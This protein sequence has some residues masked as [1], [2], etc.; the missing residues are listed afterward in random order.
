QARTAPHP[1]WARWRPARAVHGH[2]ERDPRPTGLAAALSGTQ[3]PG[4]MRQG[5]PG[6]LH[7][8][9]PG[10]DQRHAQGPKALAISAHLKKT[11]AP[12]SWLWRAARRRITCQTWAC[13]PP[14]NPSSVHLQRPIPRQAVDRPRN[15]SRDSPMTFAKRCLFA[16]F[17]L[18]L[19]LA[20]AA[21][22]Q[23]LEIDIIGGNASA[24]P[25]AVVPMPYQGAG[26]AP[27]TDVSAVVQI[28]RASCRE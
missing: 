23:G 12:A 1:G 21:Q 26:T 22:E 13:P 6:R 24:L 14:P 3:K 16:F 5:G 11:V 7:A 27:L 28:G 15:P 19:P 2:L 4:Q 25:I 20:A 8:H 10:T 9:L 17:A 18:L